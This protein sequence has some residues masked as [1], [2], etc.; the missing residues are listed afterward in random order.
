MVFNRKVRRQKYGFVESSRSFAWTWEASG[1]K[2]KNL[3]NSFT[4]VFL[5][6]QQFPERCVCV[7]QKVE[8][9]LAEWKGVG[10]FQVDNIHAA[11]I[12]LDVLCWYKPLTSVDVL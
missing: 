12:F 10:R 9:S 4:P 6:G 3:V 8:S 1:K 2:G 11:V 5:G 7:L